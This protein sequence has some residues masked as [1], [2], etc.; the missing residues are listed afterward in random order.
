MLLRTSLIAALL[1]A[2]L[3]AGVAAAQDAQYFPGLQ[4]RSG[5]YAP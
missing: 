5:P 3:L 4:Y 1:A 2:P